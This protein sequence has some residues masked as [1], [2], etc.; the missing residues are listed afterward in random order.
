MTVGNTF[1]ADAVVPFLVALRATHKLIQDD[2][3]A[4]GVVS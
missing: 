3:E 4:A 2:P 1:P